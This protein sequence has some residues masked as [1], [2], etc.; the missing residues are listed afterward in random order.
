MASTTTLKLPEKL[1]ARIARIAAQT[2]RSPHAVMVEA[3]EREVARTERVREFV[4]EA[5]ASD[6]LGGFSRAAL[7]LRTAIG[8]VDVGGDERERF[9]VHFE[10][11]PERTEI[12]PGEEVY[13]VVEARAS[14]PFIG[15]D[16]Q[17][18]LVFQTITPDPDAVQVSTEEGWRI[19][20]TRNPESVRAPNARRLLDECASRL[21]Q[22]GHVVIQLRRRVFEA[23]GVLHA[24]LV[25]PSHLLLVAGCRDHQA[26]RTLGFVPTHGIP[27]AL[28]MAHGLAGGHARIGFLLAPPY[29]PL[30]VAAP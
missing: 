3:L 15:Q 16:A 14:R 22:S 8:F 11:D 20:L 25:E 21:A 1:K 7:D 9:A 12:P 5:L 27:S 23:D 2:G 30:E 13:S 28:E 17:R 4:R 29:F 19:Y 24:Y 18:S 10:F 26:A 6:D